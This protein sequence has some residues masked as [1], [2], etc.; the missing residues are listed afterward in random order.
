MIPIGLNL[1]RKLIAKRSVMR[2]YG[3]ILGRASAC[4]GTQTDR[5]GFAAVIGRNRTRISALERINEEHGER[6]AATFVGSETRR[7]PR[8]KRDYGASQYAGHAARKRQNGAGDFSGASF[9]HYGVRCASSARMETVE[10]DGPTQR[11]V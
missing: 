2:W 9:E 7:L 8:R 4:C 6:S 5:G 3:K 1:P 10:T 11:R